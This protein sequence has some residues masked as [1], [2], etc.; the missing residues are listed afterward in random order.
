MASVFGGAGGRGSR[1]SVSNLRNLSN[2]LRPNGQL[3]NGKLVISPTNE[4]ETMQ[5]LN[6]R[7]AGYLSK[8]RMLEESNSKLEDQIKEVLKKRGTGVERDWSVYEQRLATLKEQVSYIATRLL[9]Q[10]SSSTQ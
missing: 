7:L 1:I 9:F 2:V 4:K 6:D 5:G 8:V 10:C 3:D